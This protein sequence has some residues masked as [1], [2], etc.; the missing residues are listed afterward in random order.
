MTL[1][2]IDSLQN[3]FKEKVGIIGITKYIYHLALE[4]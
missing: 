2:I 1:I 4:I 3:S